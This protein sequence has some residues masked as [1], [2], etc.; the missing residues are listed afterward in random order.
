[1]AGETGCAVHTPLWWAVG[2]SVL[3]GVGVGTEMACGGWFAGVPAYTCSACSSFCSRKWSDDAL[4]PP[5]RDTV[6]R[7]SR[8]SE[9]VAVVVGPDGL[10]VDVQENVDEEVH[11]ESDGVEDED[12]GDVR[13]VV[14]GEEGHL[15]LCGGE[16]EEA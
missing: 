10:R 2:V 3:V 9:T 4:I 12:V 1:M 13:D 15:L 11:E 14:G 8:Y 7:Q 6:H 5:A 16:E